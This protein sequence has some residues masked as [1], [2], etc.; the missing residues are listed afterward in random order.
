MKKLSV[1][2]ISILMV[3]SLVS[4]TAFADNKPVFKAETVSGKAGTTIEL[5]IKLS[6]NKGFWGVTINVLFNTKVLSV[7][8]IKNN[9]DV[10]RNGEFT[11]GPSDFS[12]GY[13]R[14]CAFSNNINVNNTSNGTLCTIVFNVKDDAVPGEYPIEFEYDEKSACDI[15]AKY[16]SINCEDGLVRILKDNEENPTV[17][18]VNSGD[19]IAKAENNKL[20]TTNTKATKSDNKTKSIDK[21]VTD[22][23][24]QAITN[25][26]GDKVT[27]TQNVDSD[28]S[29]S[30]TVLQNDNKDKGSIEADK[31][32]EKDTLS[33]T[34]TV[35]IILG[36]VVAAGV[37]AA[38]FVFAIKK[39]K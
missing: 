31:E 4:F 39:K 11:I 38:G 19:V 12:K 24:G 21:I 13:V 33:V 27:V 9:N 29:E 30:E 23:N 6:N 18:K 16:V 26:N 1:M 7:A 35:L 15:D 10:F 8:E 5:P 14:V 20:V 22:K 28:Y 3:V 36:A 32:Q 25:E 37:V 2:F 17:K 34:T